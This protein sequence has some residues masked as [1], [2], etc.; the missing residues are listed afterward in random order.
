MAAGYQG[1]GHHISGGVVRIAQLL[2]D[3]G[4]RECVARLLATSRGDSAVA[5]KVIKDMRRWMSTP[6]CPVLAIR[7]TVAPRTSKGHVRAIV[8]DAYV[9]FLRGQVH[10]KYR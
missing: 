5:N 10:L 7:R 2:E 6:R 4:P 3:G 8:V 1:L 9:S